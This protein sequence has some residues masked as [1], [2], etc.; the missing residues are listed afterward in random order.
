MEFETD[1]VDGC[2]F[3][4]LGLVVGAVIVT[5]VVLLGS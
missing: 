1:G 5:T 4:I 3:F 2:L